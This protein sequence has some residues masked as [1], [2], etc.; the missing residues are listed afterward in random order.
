MSNEFTKLAVRHPAAY[1]LGNGG[2]LSVIALAV[3]RLH[4]AIALAVGALFALV[5]WTLW[6]PGGIA[7]RRES[8]IGD[9]PVRMREIVK[10]L[11]VTLVLT[12]LVVLVYALAE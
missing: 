9:E 12:G 2:V 6:R 5:N 1:S 11:V 3:F 10:F 4:P 7:R 8:E